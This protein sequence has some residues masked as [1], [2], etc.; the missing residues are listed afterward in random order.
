MESV[1]D[2][3]DDQEDNHDTTNA[4]DAANADDDL[5]DLRAVA[6]LLRT[7]VQV[8]ARGLAAY[9]VLLEAWCGVCMICYH[10]PQ[11]GSG[12]AAHAHHDFHSCP[13]PQRF[14]YLD[15]KWRATSEARVR[16]RSWF[17]DFTACWLYYNPQVVCDQQ[18]HSQCKFPDIIL[19]LG[20]A[21]AAA[22]PGP[23]LEP[24]DSDDDDDN[25]EADIMMSNMA[26]IQD[27]EPAMMVHEPNT[28]TPSGSETGSNNSSSAPPASRHRTHGEKRLPGA[29]PAHPARSTAAARRLRRR[30]DRQ[31]SR[32]HQDPPMTILYDDFEGLQVS[33]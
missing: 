29:A 25:V 16:W 6:E 12:R 15:T 33:C 19:L 32:M 22:A 20:A 5:T 8:H 27:P 23:Q 4:E 31:R 28:G 3:E 11:V 21:G 30:A 26:D 17:K 2:G 7:Q 13:N 18:Q 14:Q 10:L 9:I 24:D 1:I